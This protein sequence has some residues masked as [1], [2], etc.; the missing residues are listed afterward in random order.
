MPSAQVS[1]MARCPRA[2]AVCQATDGLV[3]QGCNLLS[4]PEYRISTIS[5]RPLKAG[6]KR[7]YCAPHAMLAMLKPQ[8]C[9]QEHK[10]SN[11]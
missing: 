5:T 10:H 2:P 8:A 4:C 1:R 6:S 11:T 7:A 9:P 3:L